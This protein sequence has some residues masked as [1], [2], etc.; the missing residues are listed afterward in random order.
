[1]AITQLRGVWFLL[2][3][4]LSPAMAYICNDDTSLPSDAFEDH[5]CFCGT[6]QV[7]YNYRR[8]FDKYNEAFAGCHEDD[9]DAVTIECAFL[10]N[11]ALPPN[12]NRTSLSRIP[13]VT[14]GALIYS[15]ISCL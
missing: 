1:M 15:K 12:L 14:N 11:E 2:S 7:A 13:V 9:G 8:L 6:E 4:G 5:G 10:Q 3:V